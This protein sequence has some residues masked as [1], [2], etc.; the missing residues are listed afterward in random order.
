MKLC[1][2]ILTLIIGSHITLMAQQSKS[3][4]SAPKEDIKVNREYD[5]NGNLVRFDSLYS[6]SWSGD[7]LLLDSLQ[8]GNFPGAFGNSFDFFSDSSLFDLPFFQGFGP[9]FGP[10]SQDKDSILNK[11]GLLHEFN[12]SQ[13]STH[14]GMLNLDDFFKQFSDNQNDSTFKHSP[15]NNQFNFSPDSMNEMMEMIQNQMK[16]IEEQT[17]RHFKK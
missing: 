10:F 8:G 13:D 2:I 11:L 3:N 1:M 15:L 16:E 14:S 7:T 6:Y 9:S 4:Q 12:F 5:E 17:Q